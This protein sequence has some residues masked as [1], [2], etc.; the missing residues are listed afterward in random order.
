MA[1]NTHSSDNTRKPDSSSKKES[2]VDKVRDQVRTQ[3]N[4][5]LSKKK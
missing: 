1:I 5:T 4:S 3:V 2:A